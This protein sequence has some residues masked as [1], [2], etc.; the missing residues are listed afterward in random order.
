MVITQQ[1]NK[2]HPIPKSSCKK[3][4]WNADDIVTPSTFVFPYFRV[5]WE[6]P[7]PTGTTVQILG[8]TLTVT[9]QNL[10]GEFNGTING[11]IVSLK[12][13][14]SE[15]VECGFEVEV[16]AGNPAAQILVITYPTYDTPTLFESNQSGTINVSYY[17]GSNEQVDNTVYDVR[18]YDKNDREIARLPLQYPNVND[19]Y[20]VSDNCVSFWNV[21]LSTS[22]PNKPLLGI[23]FY[24]L[25]SK[26][27]NF[28]KQIKY[29]IWRKH[30]AACNLKASEI[31]E[32]ESFIVT[33]SV[34]DRNYN[35]EQHYLTDAI[36]FNM[37]KGKFLTQLDKLVVCQ[38]MYAAL[39]ICPAL[40]SPKTIYEYFY[41]IRQFQEG[42]HTGNDVIIPATSENTTRCG[43]MFN[44]GQN[45]MNSF[46]AG[47]LPTSVTIEFGAEISVNGQPPTTTYLTKP[48]PVILKED[49]CC[50][51]V[52][53]YQEQLGAINPICFDKI[54]ES[55]SVSS[56]KA[57]YGNKCDQRVES[58]NSE[59]ITTYKLE[60]HL[61]DKT[62]KN[63]FA[64][65]TNHWIDINGELVPVLVK[66]KNITISD[67]KKASSKIELTIDVIKSKT[68]D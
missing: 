57:C 58:V 9:N 28:C 22:L 12:I 17:E 60:T 25:A 63:V 5:Y 55:V 44:V 35:F 34:H 59:V 38:G 33:N 7:L 30:P 27:P 6:N 61:S 16:V 36:I 29:R 14:F 8:E 37:N 4:C 66:K 47:P 2:N 45:L 53:Y 51:V 56:N 41:R 43:Y 68:H 42:V 11:L 21:G 49:C 32:S 65:A 62:L 26:D 46:F 23:G 1:P 10:S 31:L 67:K 15:I 50:D 48:F 13:M 18:I 19:D 3:I 64:K 40:D 52:I 20:T 39:W 24:S 54:K